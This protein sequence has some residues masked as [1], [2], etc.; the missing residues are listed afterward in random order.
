MPDAPV[1]PPRAGHDRAGDQIEALEITLHLFRVIIVETGI[2]VFKHVVL[3]FNS[4][5]PQQ[6]QHCI[7]AGR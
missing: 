2:S 6:A 1:G 5:N 4:R 7:A 3:P